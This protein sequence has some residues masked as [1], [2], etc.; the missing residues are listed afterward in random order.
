M[1]ICQVFRVRSERRKKKRGKDYSQVKPE[2]ECDS[3]K[4]T[5]ENEENIS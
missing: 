5:G 1:T 2:T 4:G 3:E